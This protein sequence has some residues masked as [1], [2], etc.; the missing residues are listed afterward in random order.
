MRGVAG[1]LL[2]T[3]VAV[4]LC[5]GLQAQSL[6]QAKKLYNEG[7]YAEAKPAFERLVER[8]PSNSSYNHWYGVCCFE[9]GDYVTA[10]KHLLIAVKRKVQ[11]AYRYMGDLYFLTYRFEEAIDMYDEYISVISKKKQDTEPFELKADLA[12]K[13]QRMLDRVENVQIIDSI[14]V[15]KQDILEAYQLSEESGSLHSF[16]RFFNKNEPAVSTVYMNQK[17]QNIYYGQKNEADFFN[18]YTE[19]KLID[20]WGDI[21]QLPANINH[22]E[23]D[24]NFPF[25]LSDGATIYFASNNKESLGG[26]DIFVTRYNTN[27]DTYLTP[28]QMG[29]PYN[30]TYNDYMLVIDEA[31]ELG[32]FVSDRFQ[33][34]DKAC[35]YLFIPDAAR[36]RLNS[37]DIEEK[38]HRAMITAIEDSWTDTDYSSLI[39]KAYL[40]PTGSQGPQRDFEFIIN[41]NTVYYTL[42]DIKSADARTYYGRVLT[43][44]QQIS[45]LKQKI[46]LA[47]LEYTKANQATRGQLGSRI[48]QDEQQL[49]NLLSQ[50]YDLEKKARNIEIQYLRSHQPR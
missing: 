19:S 18:L 7:Q 40:E 5:V 32:W 35:I 3:I 20:K 1:K 13:G 28:E 11:E 48:L 25:V 44:K 37:D 26:Y 41:D 6:D 33:P 46:A 49:D 15:D 31:K 29:M 21:K 4:L 50:P 39:A 8:V 16:N 9:T 22:P 17:Q 2:Y 24:A 30:S 23:S 34:E 38:R 14:V 43:A 27:T 12:R 10:E 42:A 47:R 36:N 45:E